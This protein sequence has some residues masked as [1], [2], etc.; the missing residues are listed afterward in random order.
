VVRGWRSAW[1][2]LKYEFGARQEDMASIPFT[3]SLVIIFGDLSAS[4]G[5]LVAIVVESIVLQHSNVV[6]TT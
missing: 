3:C 4:L 6:Y 1:D 2:R 5:N